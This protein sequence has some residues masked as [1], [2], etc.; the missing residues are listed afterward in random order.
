M[1]A[2]W[3]WLYPDPAYRAAI[4]DEARA[5]VAEKREITGLETEIHCKSGE[6]KVIAWNSRPFIDARGTVTGRSR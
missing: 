1:G 5:I 6:Y 4:L 3:A 2:V